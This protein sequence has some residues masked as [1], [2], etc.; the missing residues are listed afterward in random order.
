M[1]PLYTGLGGYKLT[2]AERELLRTNR[3]RHMT[4][5][6]TQHEVELRDRKTRV[7]PQKFRRHRLRP[8]GVLKP[9]AS[10]RAKE[11]GRGDCSTLPGKDQMAVGNA[12]AATV[13]PFRGCRKVCD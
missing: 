11:D 4:D 5:F 7:G 13:N 8:P 3:D 6:K 9:K 2:D 1:E 12:Y 10:D